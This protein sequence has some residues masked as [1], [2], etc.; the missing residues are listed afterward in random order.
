MINSRKWGG[1]RSVMGKAILM[2]SLGLV[3]QEFGQLSYAFYNDIYKTPG[4]IH[5]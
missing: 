2:F 5:R 4:P 3:A 1:L